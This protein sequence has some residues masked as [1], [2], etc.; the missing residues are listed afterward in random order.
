MGEVDESFWHTLCPKRNVN[1]VAA[2]I[3]SKSERVDVG[4][5]VELYEHDRVGGQKGKVVRIL[6]R[7]RTSSPRDGMKWLC[8][9]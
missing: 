8:C 3:N 4:S 2:C 6:N 9:V 5:F 7:D 1:I